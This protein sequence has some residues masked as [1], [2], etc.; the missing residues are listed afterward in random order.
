MA[1][2]TKFEIIDRISKRHMI[3]PRINSSCPECSSREILLNPRT[4]P[5]GYYI[6]RCNICG[7]H[8]YK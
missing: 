6:W 7:Y 4:N 3:E 5:E 2:S 8:W 1:V